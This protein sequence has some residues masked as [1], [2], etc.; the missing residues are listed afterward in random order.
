MNW[1]EVVINT[2]TSGAEIIPE[3]LYEAGANGSIIEDPN[4]IKLYQKNKDEWD[5]IDESL[6]NDY[7]PGVIVKGY[8]ADDEKLHDRIGYIK[9]KLA[10]LKS[11]NKD[12]DIGSCNVEFINVKD[13]DWTSGWKKYY[14]P[15]HASDKIVIKPTWESYS[16]LPG[17]KII[18]IDPGM[19]FGTGTHETT[20]M[21]I[22]ML[23]KYVEQDNSVID[24][25]CGTGILG[26]TAANLGASSVE[27]VDIEPTSVKVAKQNVVH[28]HLQ[29][30]VNVSEGDLLKSIDL[31]KSDVIVAN[32]IAD[33]IIKLSADIGHYLKKR[34][35]FI[36]SGIIKSRAD[37]VENILVQNNFDI[38]DKK[39][40]GEWVAFACRLKG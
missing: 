20:M 7:K 16:A 10:F 25:G 8:F 3:V 6:L 12:I 9:S 33:I 38:I 5:H 4:D 11:I 37:E 22:Q 39:T 19:A 29:N 26:I 27:A 31:E 15:F 14:K 36:S 23:E 34:G 17:E 30:I 21:C 2:T 35:I 24:V 40:K 18:E 28:N 32:I 13:E 1:I